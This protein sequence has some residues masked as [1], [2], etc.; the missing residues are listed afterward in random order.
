VASFAVNEK[1]GRYIIKERIGRGG[2]AEVYRGY[3]TNLERDVAIKVM[4]AYLSDDAMFRERFER[5]AKIIATFNHPHIVRIYDFERLERTHDCVYYMVMPYLSGGTLRERLLTL[6]QENR[7]MSH[8]EVHAI[9]RSL[10]DALGYAHK[11]GMVHRDVKPANV[12]FDENGQVILTD[13]GIARWA[14]GSGLTQEGTTVGTPTYMSPEQAESGNVDGRSDIYSLGVILYELL[15][16]HAP[17]ED[18]GS[19][20]IILKHLNEPPPSIT[21]FVHITNRSLDSVIQKALAKDENKR[22]QTT[23]EFLADL[24]LAFSEPTVELPRIKSDALPSR[25][26]APQVSSS[27]NAQTTTL[28]PQRTLQM[29]TQQI[30]QVVTRSPIGLLFVGLAL[31]GLMTVVGMLNNPPQETPQVENAPFVQSM[32][33]S[34][35]DSGAQSMTGP[36]Y[37]TSTFDADSDSNR[38]WPMGNDGFVVRELTDDG[39]YRFSNQRPDSAMTTLAAADY[40]YDNISIVLKATLEDG[41]GTASGYGIVFRYQDENNYNV[42]AVDGMGRYSIWALESGQWR[43]LRGEAEAWTPNGVIK[44]LGE[45][46]TIAVDNSGSTFMG[47]VNNVKVVEVQYD[48]PM[49]GQIGVYLASTPSSTA[50]IVMDNFGVTRFVPAMTAPEDYN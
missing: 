2:M 34:E 49:N 43:E 26:A 39:F 18:D 24:A 31:I 14:S 15:T 6:T 27:T 50:S 45:P 8:D 22:Y 23:D 3:D 46:N 19:L 1:I 13:F 20:S 48:G 41:S 36:L 42:F 4:Y 17:F 11:R 40:T 7:L 47:Y 38:Y 30:T 37:F 9:I 32:T 44:P 33:G 35:T 28:Q 16:L 10:G 25:R 29:V 5:E 12:M 21:K